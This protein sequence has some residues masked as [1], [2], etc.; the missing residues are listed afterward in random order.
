VTPA[1][2]LKVETKRWRPSEILAW[3]VLEPR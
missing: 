1:M 3:R 2:A